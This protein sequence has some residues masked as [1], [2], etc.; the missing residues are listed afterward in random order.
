MLAHLQL[1]AAVSHAGLVA[2]LDANHGEYSRHD[3]EAK[4]IVDAVHEISALR[5]RY[6]ETFM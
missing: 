5:T 2:G 3:N 4:E 1:C 6:M